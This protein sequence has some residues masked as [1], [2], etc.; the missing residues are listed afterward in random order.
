MIKRLFF[1]GAAA[2][3]ASITFSGTA[4]A[5]SPNFLGGGGL[6]KPGG[7]FFDFGSGITSTSNAPG[8]Q[9]QGEFTFSNPPGAGNGGGGT[10]TVRATCL[11]VMPS[12]NP[13]GMIAAA[14]GTVIAV[15]TTNKSAIGTGVDIEAFDTADPTISADQINKQSDVPAEP[16]GS[17]TPV[18][19]C[20]S[21]FGCYSPVVSGDVVIHPA[22]P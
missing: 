1:L 18:P 2:V 11:E 21:S 5:S 4:Y 7:V 15:S 19:P 22:K 16:Q 20:P 6:V 12:S 13:P 17:C 3:L 9:V 14:S 8:A 10:T